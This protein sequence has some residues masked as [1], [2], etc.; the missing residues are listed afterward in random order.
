MFCEPRS[1]LMLAILPLPAAP[2][3]IPP[4]TVMFGAP[5]MLWVWTPEV[6]LLA[7]ICATL[8]LP[9]PPAVIWML[10]PAANTRFCETPLSLIRATLPLP[11]PSPAVSTMLPPSLTVMVW[12]PVALF[13]EIWAIEVVAVPL[14]PVSVMPPAPTV[15]A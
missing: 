10:P 15:M 1:L 3:A 5:P 6:P 8:L 13:W 11:D 4:V 9:A 14:P 2:P 7:R 12:V